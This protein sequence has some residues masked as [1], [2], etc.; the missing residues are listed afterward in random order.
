M[1]D[2]DVVP[3]KEDYL[4]NGPMPKYDDP[5]K[6]VC[7]NCESYVWVVAIGRDHKWKWNC[8]NCTRDLK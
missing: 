4:D 8:T 5:N 6:P 1:I 7:I 3:E 2:V